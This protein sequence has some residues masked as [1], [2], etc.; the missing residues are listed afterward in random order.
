VKKGEGLRL[1]RKTGY[2]GNTTIFFD[3]F[4]HSGHTVMY[5]NT[6]QNVLQKKKIWFI[7]IR[8]N[9]RKNV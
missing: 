3:K 2:N 1:L 4:C 6:E 8:I 9:N 5:M 7:Q